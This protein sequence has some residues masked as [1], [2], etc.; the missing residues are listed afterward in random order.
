MLSQ[1]ALVCVSGYCTCGYVSFVYIMFSVVCVNQ[2]VCSKGGAE[3]PSQGIVPFCTVL[4]H[5]SKMKHARSANALLS[6]YWNAFLLLRF[7][8]Y[9]C[10]CVFSGRGM[11]ACT[12]H[13][14]EVA[15]LVA[16]DDCAER[17]EQLLEIVLL[18]GVVQVADEQLV[19]RIRFQRRLGSGLTVRI[20]PTDKGFKMF[21]AYHESEDTLG[22]TYGVFTLPNTDSQTDTYTE[23]E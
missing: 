16:L 12:D 2:S 5:M 23:T 20:V 6:I 18:D 10:A 14:A 1:Y 17:L 8:L 19:L 11:R 21:L 4:P 15:D 9:S 13:E 7:C 3:D 22:P